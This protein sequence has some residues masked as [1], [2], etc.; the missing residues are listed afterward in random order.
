MS[1]QKT[2]SIEAQIKKIEKYIVKQKIIITEVSALIS[3]K[4]DFRTRNITRDKGKYFIMA[5][6]LTKK[7]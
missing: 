6:P 2:F 1:T 4:S 5:T 7:M 3:D